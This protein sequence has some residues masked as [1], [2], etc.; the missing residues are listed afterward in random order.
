MVVEFSQA[1]AEEVSQEELEEGLQGVFPEE[2]EDLVELLR[3]EQADL[4]EEVRPATDS[5]QTNLLV[6]GA[7]LGQMSV[8]GS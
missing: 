5:K 2:Q 6:K 4:A 1:V 7:L 3:E 8:P